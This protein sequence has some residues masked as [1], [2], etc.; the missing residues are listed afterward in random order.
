[1]STPPYPG[2]LPESTTYSTVDGQSSGTLRP[3]KYIWPKR[4]AVI[5]AGLALVGGIGFGVKTLLHNDD[6]AATSQ[7]TVQSASPAPGASQA[8]T[9]PG[10]SQAPQATTA[11]MKLSNAVTDSAG[12]LYSEQTAEVTSAVKSLQ[13]ARDVRMWVVYVDAFDAPPVEWARKTG[14]LT[15]LGDRDAILAIATKQ[16]KY[17]FLVAPAASNE[18]EQAVNDL[19]RNKI[20]P[21]LRNSDFAAAAVVAAAGLQALG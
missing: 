17:A 4:I 11:P 13:T 5:V 20:E 1:M 10:G 14:S 12:A 8:P 19:R 2:S 6:T 18:S 15:K 21:Q 7:E 16:R 9:A 3:I